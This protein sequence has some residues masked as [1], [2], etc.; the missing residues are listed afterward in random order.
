MQSN[1]N[2]SEQNGDEKNIVVPEGIQYIGAH[3]YENKDIESIVLPSSL[4]GIGCFAFRGCKKLVEIT[5]P[6]GVLLIGPRAFENS[7]IREAKLPSTIKGFDVYRSKTMGPSGLFTNCTDLKKLT[8]VGNYNEDIIPMSVYMEEYRASNR[9]CDYASMNDYYGSKKLLGDVNKKGI[10][11]GTQMEEIRATEIGIEYIPTEWRKYAIIGFIRAYMGGVVIN[12]DISAGYFSSIRRKRDYTEYVD[13]VCI[14]Q[15]LVKEKVIKPDKADIYLELAQKSNN[16]EVIALLLNYINNN[17]SSIKMTKLNLNEKSP[18]AVNKKKAD[19]DFTDPAYIKKSFPVK[20]GGFD[21][22]NAVTRY[23]GDSEVVVF[24]AEVEGIKIDGIGDCGGATPKN[25]Q[26][27]RKVILPEGYKCIGDRAFKD[28]KQLET[29]VIPEG[30]RT[31]GDEAFSGCISL[32]RVVLPKSL[33]DVGKWSFRD[34]GVEEIYVQNP[35]MRF[36]GSNWLRGC[37]QYKVYAPEGSTILEKRYGALL[38][39]IPN[40]E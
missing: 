23:K 5:I 33:K 13:D 35:Q 21:C 40:I 22:R 10:F 25:Y 16:T 3:Q 17:N 24:P 32:K 37:S 15:F 7:G 11:V 12:E 39:G 8:I 27:I 2:I 31:I 28:C 6:S 34:S 18:K 26:S 14:M 36:E 19:A 30:I 9:V 20:D 1:K 4:K 29:I 38:S